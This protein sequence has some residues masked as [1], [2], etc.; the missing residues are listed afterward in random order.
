MGFFVRVKSFVGSSAGQM[1]SE[2]GD[3]HDGSSPLVSS[4]AREEEGKRETCECAPS[5]A[6]FLRFSHLAQ[7]LCQ[8]ERGLCP[9]KYAR[10]RL[11]RSARPPGDTLR[12]PTF[13]QFSP[14]GHSGARRGG[15]LRL[16]GF[17]FRHGLSV[18]APMIA[19]P[20]PGLQFL[21][22]AKAMIAEL[23]RVM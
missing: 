14:F 11:R 5:D 9:A 23:L 2:I 8:R 17:S 13:H 18:C 20:I 6:Q 16:M 10:V 3:L 19:N 1:N 4:H 7:R 22:T 12:T 21:P 15:T